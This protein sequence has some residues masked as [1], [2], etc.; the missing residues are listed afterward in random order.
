MAFKDILL[1][2]RS[3]PDPTSPAAIEQTEEA[4]ASIVRATDR[5]EVDVA[6]GV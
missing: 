6:T 5:P 1:Q 4:A 2:L 3:Y